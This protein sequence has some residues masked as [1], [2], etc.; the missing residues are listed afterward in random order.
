[1][2]PLHNTGD[3][4]AR[5][6]D[7]VVVVLLGA[8]TL[9]VAWLVDRGWIPHDDG[10]LAQAAE[11]ALLGERPHIDFQDPY[12][13]ALTYWNALAFEVLGIRLFS[14]RAMLFMSFL[15]FLAALFSLLR[16]FVGP[17]EAAAAAA[18][19]AVWSLPGYPAAMPT[20]YNLFLATA[21]LLAF[22]RFLE[23]GR[24]GWLFAAGAAAGLS[25]LF[26]LVGVFTLA[27]LLFALAFCA[28]W[29]SPADES[30]RGPSKRWAGFVT[31]GA[32]VWA[33]LLVR[34]V[35]G[36]NVTPAHVFHYLLPGLGLALGVAMA[37]WTSPA[38]GGRPNLGSQ[39]GR[40]AAL[41]LGFLIPILL[42]ALPYAT[43]GTLAELW[44]GVVLLPQRRFAFASGAP[45]PLR[46]LI[47][48]L[49][50]FLLLI[51]AV[52]A[53]ERWRRAASWILGSTLATALVLGRVDPVFSAA[54]YAV[55][56]LPTLLVV[57]GLLAL[58]KRYR[59]TAGTGD[60]ELLVPTAAATLAVLATFS[61]VQFPFTGP[62][63]FFYVAPLLPLAGAALVA[64]TG[65]H[66]RR[67]AALVLAFA[68]CFALLWVN[69]ASILGLGAGRFE[70]RAEGARLDAPRGGIRVSAEDKAVYEELVATLQAISQGPVTFATPDS[71]Q[72]YFL[73]GLRNATPVFYDFFDQA[74]G[75]TARI[76]QIL[77]RDRVNVVVLNT[78]LQFSPP[79]PPQ[80]IA[81]IEARFPSARMVGPFIVRWRDSG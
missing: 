62:V 26:K 25:V 42:Y 78:A 74:P 19:A 11:R 61:M 13:G 65:P 56:A 79:P 22:V 31:A 7:P 81:E 9:Y 63:Y 53:P 30:R 40:G 64:L 46:R 47:P 70:A 50:A 14:L 28:P 44:E 20:W 48:S 24:A 6:W 49:P 51:I 75:R 67:P 54:W 8:A 18:A 16:R 58:A 39:I 57:T 5:R 10:L 69:H 45:F 43:T 52:E 73:S 55:R 77:E 38:G 68:T 37:A 2:S 36:G 72:V 80:L 60:Q 4:K 29:V 15:P 34:L 33:V 23:S 76:L 66:S 17:R 12:T 21:A 27:G 41:I 59:S 71:P 1:M 32:L 3:T 35:A